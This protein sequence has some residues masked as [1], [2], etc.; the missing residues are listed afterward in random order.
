[1][2][3]KRNPP[4][5]AEHIGSLL[6]PEEV[7][8][9]FSDHALGKIGDEDL[10]DVEDRHIREAVALQERIGLRSITDGEYRRTIYWG[11]FPKAVSGF[12][13]MEAEI[14]F[15]DGSGR[16]MKYTTA[17]VNGKLERRRAI[18][19]DEFLYVKSLTRETPKTTLPSPASQH[20]FRFREGVS[21]KAYPDV[22][23]F[24][25]D[26]ARIYREEFAELAARGAR[27]VQLDDVSLPLL[28]D[29]RLRD[30]VRRRGYHPE[31]LVDLYID[32]TNRSLEG[33]SAALTVGMHLCRGNNQGKWLGEGGYEPVAEK[34]F[35]GI[36][37]DFFCLEYDSPRAGS[38]EPL[39]FMPAEKTV[40]LGL[41]STKTPAL[42]S[43]D[44]LKRRIEE[45]SHHVP[46]ERLGLSP[47]CG[48]AST[49]P[50]NPL[51]FDDQR[52]KLELVV[53]VARSLWPD[54]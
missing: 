7:K 51:T 20:Y 11:H 33:R 47:Q 19:V 1:V 54:A 34:I 43:P 40:I 6:R 36:E 12:T 15:Q 23:E 18:A 31:E 48:F 42:E 16:T 5:R 26:V 41:A 8:K 13:E 27:Y 22:D 49:A 30:Q 39:R 9:A 35:G 45:A 10:K 17:V 28:C 21:E 46:L 4:F 32:L 37:V 24:Y 50:G 14:E 3:S 44:E 29:E 25:A 53:S 52:R 38:F 2:T